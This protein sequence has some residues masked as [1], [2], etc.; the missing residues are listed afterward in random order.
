[1]DEDMSIRGGLDMEARL[2]IKEQ[3]LNFGVREHDYP[4]CIIGI[5]SSLLTRL[6]S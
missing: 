6:P 4:Y 5:S 3:R 2:C 1:V